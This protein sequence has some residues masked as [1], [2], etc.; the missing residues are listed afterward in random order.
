MRVT[1]PYVNQRKTLD[2]MMAIADLIGIEN[3]VALYELLNGRQTYFPSVKTVADILKNRELVED[4]KDERFNKYRKHN[5][6]KMLKKYGMSL[7]TFDGKLR[8]YRK[9]VLRY[10]NKGYK[11]VL[12]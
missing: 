7:N 11:V 1:M 6:K 9:K 4:F 5:A 12:V 2:Q 10:Q 8:R 3:T